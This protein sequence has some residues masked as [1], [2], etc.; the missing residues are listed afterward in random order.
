MYSCFELQYLHQGDGM[1][2]IWQKLPVY[3]QV[4]WHKCGQRRADEESRM[5]NFHEFVRFVERKAVHFS[6]NI[7]EVV[8]D[9]DQRKS[10]SIKSCKYFQHDVGV[11]NTSN[12][13]TTIKQSKILQIVITSFEARQRDRRKL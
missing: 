11:I 1:K 9:T 7:F 4:N 6:K 2:T 5:P 8:R 13:Q 10:Y 12:S 3:M